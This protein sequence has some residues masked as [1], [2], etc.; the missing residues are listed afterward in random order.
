MGA[1]D[2]KY[3]YLYLKSCKGSHYSTSVLPYRID[4]KSLI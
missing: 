1:E 3:F 2:A 4:I